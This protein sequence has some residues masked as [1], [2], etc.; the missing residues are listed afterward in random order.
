MFLKLQLPIKK[1]EEF[2]SYTHMQPKEKMIVRTVDNQMYE[3]VDSKWVLVTEEDLKARFE[4]R[5]K[6][7]N[8]KSIEE[9]NKIIQQRQLENRARYMKHLNMP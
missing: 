3:Y 2:E 4:K 7:K 6:E 9:E 5:M 8:Q 1:P